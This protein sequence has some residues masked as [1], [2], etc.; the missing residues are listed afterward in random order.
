M[1]IYVNNALKESFSNLFCLTI[2]PS[3]FRLF[4]DFVSLPHSLFRVHSLL[5]D[6]QC[7]VIRELLFLS[8]SFVL[9]GSLL[10]IACIGKRF[11][12]TE[13]YLSRE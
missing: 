7:R 9:I 5:I 3:A 12:T 1:G 2:S 10:T 4:P 8:S 11:E 13:F 6:K